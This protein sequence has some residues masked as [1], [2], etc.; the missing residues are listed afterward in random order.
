MQKEKSKMSEPMFDCLLDMVQ[1]AWCSKKEGK[2]LWSTFSKSYTSNLFKYWFVGSSG[3]PM[4]YPSNNP[5]EA[6]NSVIKGS[7][8]KNRSGMVM[9]GLQL[10]KMFKL[11]K[12][13][14]FQQFN[15]I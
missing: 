2:K 11:S 7:T 5:I 4:C 9:K 15:I 1:S 10:S 13:L 3:V 6:N 12:A 8:S 14:R